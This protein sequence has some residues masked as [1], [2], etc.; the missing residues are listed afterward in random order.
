MKSYTG[1]LKV[2]THL[3]LFAYTIPLRN[4]SVTFL[5]LRYAEVLNEQGKTADALPY[6]SLVKTRAKL[7]DLTS[8][9]QADVR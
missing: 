8:T 6:S 7:P 9:S 2:R 3:E 4:G 5:L 1:G